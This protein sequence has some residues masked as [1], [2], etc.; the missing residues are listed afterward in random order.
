MSVLITGA[1]GFLGYYLTD[2]LLQKGH[3]VIATGR[4]ECRLPFH[5]RQDF[6]YIPMDFKEPAA[7]LSV[8][9]RCK[10]ETVVHAGAMS[11]PDDCELNQELAFNIN[12]QGTANVLQASEKHQS[13]FILVSSDFVFDG[14]RGMYREHDKPNPVSY[15]GSTK[16]QAELA[17]QQYI[18]DWSI[19]RTV[20]V[21]GRPITG[22]SNLLSIV[23][24]KLEKGEEYC[25]VDD[26]L[27]TPTYVE[28]LA[29]GIAAVIEI[30]AK[31]I[32][33]VSG[34]EVLT[35]YQM[36]IRTAEYLKLDSS[37]IKRVTAA[38]FSQPAKRPP[39]TGFVI[40]KAKKQFGFHPVSFEIGLEK[41][42]NGQ[43]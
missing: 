41:T 40:D 17:V 24:E 10:P 38:D 2:L 29:T 37:L 4:G 31:G 9:E 5:G 18:F 14:E 35:P 34:E 26:Q 8:F 19:I 13:F 42:F 39:R 20:L 15:Y 11:K 25:V 22:R 6:Q 21:Y 27:R 33:H 43:K 36:A 23:K 16:L 30:K 3:Q 32:F 7:I 1:N 12:V 28:D